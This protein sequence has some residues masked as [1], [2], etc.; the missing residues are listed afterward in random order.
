MKYYIT[1]TE[2]R[3][4]IGIIVF[5]TIL[6]LALCLRLMKAAVDYAELIKEKEALEEIVEVQKQ[7]LEEI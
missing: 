4:V 5:Y 1:K 7:R 3:I 2:K 6:G